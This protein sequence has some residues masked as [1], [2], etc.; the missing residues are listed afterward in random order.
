MITIEQHFETFIDAEAALDYEEKGETIQRI[1]DEVEKY[2][3]NDID[4]VGYIQ[5][6]HT[7][8]TPTID[9]RHFTIEYEIIDGVI[10]IK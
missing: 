9:G 3:K 4:S 10:Y 1:L 2:L 6:H 7:V 5:E 8:F